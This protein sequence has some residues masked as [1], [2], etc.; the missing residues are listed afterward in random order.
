MK[1][2]QRTVSYTAEELEELR[3]KEGDKT[4]W[5]KVDSM[6][7]EKLARLI[8]EDPDEQDLEPDWTKAKLVMPQAKKLVSLRLD[9]DVFEWFKGQ[10]KGY[11][12][13]IQAVLRA[14]MEAHRKQS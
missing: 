3:R 6:T 4:D 9:A 10:G 5:A 1:N 12:T 8:A 14:Y 11:Q 13:K 2:E 7:E